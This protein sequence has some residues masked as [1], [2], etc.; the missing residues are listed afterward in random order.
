[1]AAAFVIGLNLDQSRTV[2]LVATAMVALIKIS[3]AFP[4][5]LSSLS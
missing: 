5:V 2:G 4:D 3:E 1:M